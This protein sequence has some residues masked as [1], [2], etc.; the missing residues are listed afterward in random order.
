MP[1]S[2]SAEFG[3]VDVAELTEMD[4]ETTTS[5]EGRP[6]FAA[7]ADWDIVL[8]AVEKELPES[9]PLYRIV[10]RGGRKYGRVYMR[11][12]ADE[13]DIYDRIAKKL[14]REA[15][16]LRGIPTPRVVILDLSAPEFG[17]IFLLDPQR[18]AGPIQK[19]MRGIPELAAVF[20]TMRRWTTAFRHKYYGV[21]LDNGSSVY[22][23]PARFM[24]RYTQREWTWDFIANR[25]YPDAGEY[26]RGVTSPFAE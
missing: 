9:E 26:T 7:A 14:K 25:E 23:L 11:F 8:C 2:V 15:Q 3:H 18:I 19:I 13:R 22:R 16:Q 5:A 17:D 24:Y 21:F 6:E 1:V 12:P 4:G 10:P 20:L